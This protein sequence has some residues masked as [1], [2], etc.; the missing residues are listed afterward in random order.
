MVE[1]APLRTNYLYLDEL[2]FGIGEIA[3]HRDAET[4]EERHHKVC[5]FCF[6]GGP[7]KQVLLL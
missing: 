3:Q 7:D 1:R 2:P 6:Y 4:V 5:D